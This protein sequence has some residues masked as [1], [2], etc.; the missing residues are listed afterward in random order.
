MNTTTK[1]VAQKRLNSIEVAQYRLACVLGYKGKSPR[2][3]KL[4][5]VWLRLKRT[6]R[7]ENRIV[8]RS[9]Y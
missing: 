1:T 9:G 3:A 2:R 7:G 5:Q 4:A 6:V 8:A